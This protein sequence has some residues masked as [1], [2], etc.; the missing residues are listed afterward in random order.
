MGWLTRL[1]PTTRKDLQSIRAGEIEYLLDSIKAR[2]LGATLVTEGDQ[3]H[4]HSFQSAEWDSNRFGSDF[5]DVH[6][7]PGTEIAFPMATFKDLYVCSCG[8]E[9]IQSVRSVY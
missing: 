3:D 8:R 4:S 2:S 1:I 5:T 7:D 9:I 6:R